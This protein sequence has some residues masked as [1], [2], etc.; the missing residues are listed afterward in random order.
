MFPLY[1]RMHSSLRMM[2]A[3]EFLH[4]LFIGL[5]NLSFISGLL[6]VFSHEWCIFPDDFSASAFLCPVV[7]FTL[8]HWYGELHCFLD[9]KPAFCL[10]DKSHL[11]LWVLSDSCHEGVDFHAL[12]Y[13]GWNV[14]PGE[15]REESSSRWECYRLM[16][17]LTKVQ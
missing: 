8:F 10:W 2:L 14:I 4:L 9:I 1:G 15:L 17:F 13:L 12:I 16:L 7:F 6:R 11:F 5:K 3:P